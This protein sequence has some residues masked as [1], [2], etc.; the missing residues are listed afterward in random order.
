MDSEIE[1]IIRRANSSLDKWIRKKKTRKCNHFF[2]PHFNVQF[3]ASYKNLGPH[4]IEYRKRH[5]INNSM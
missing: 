3:L 4:F 2:S 1:N 5:T